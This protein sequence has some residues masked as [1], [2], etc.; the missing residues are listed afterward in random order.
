MVRGTGFRMPKF[1]IFRASGGTILGET[2]EHFSQSDDVNR[3]ANLAPNFERSCSLSSSS[4]RL[5][6]RGRQSSNFKKKTI[7]QVKCKFLKNHSSAL[8]GEVEDVNSSFWS[9]EIDLSTGGGLL[10]VEYKFDPS[11]V[12]PKLPIFK[13]HTMEDGGRNYMISISQKIGHFLP[14]NYIYNLW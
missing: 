13:P 4:H 6:P 5:A 12:P 9:R 3:R 10:T 8:F 2:G 7:S 14:L 11:G 1:A